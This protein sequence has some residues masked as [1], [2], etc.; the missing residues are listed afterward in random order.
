M[1]KEAIDFSLEENEEKDLQLALNLSILVPKEKRRLSDSQGDSSNSSLSDSQENSQG[2]ENNES[3][4]LWRFNRIRRVPKEAN[5]FSISL[6]E[7]F[8][9]SEEILSTVITTYDLDLEWL[10][11]NIPLIQLVPTIIVHGHQK[12]EHKEVGKM[13]MYC[14]P[15]PIPYGTHHGKMF[16]IY[17]KSRVRIA[18]STSNLNAKDYERKTQGIWMEDFPLKEKDSPASSEFEITLRDYV[19]RIKVDDT[20]LASFDF[21][22]TKAILITS[23]PGYFQGQNMFKYGHLSLQRHL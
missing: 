20:P 21:S 5:Q 1:E 13:K 23:I 14:P 22:K 15:L 8:D 4:P 3:I 18:I 7:I 9:S 17:Y 19:K 16:I 2:S 10:L 6:Q 11:E 12:E